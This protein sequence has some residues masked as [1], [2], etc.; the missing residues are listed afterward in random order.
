MAILQLPVLLPVVKGGIWKL[1]DDGHVGLWRRTGGTKQ[2]IRKVGR[3]ILKKFLFGFA[4]AV[5][6]C[7]NRAS[8]DSW[9]F[10]VR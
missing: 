4:S 10:S 7:S 1:N 6:Y 5:I 8:K 3:P 2:R 9:H